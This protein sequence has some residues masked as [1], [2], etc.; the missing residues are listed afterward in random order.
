[1]E[2][3]GSIDVI[4]KDGPKSTDHPFYPGFK[5]E[6]KVLEQG[7]ILKD[8]ALALPCDI[9]WE[10]DV[11]MKLRDGCT[12]YLDIYRRADAES[13]LPS[14]IASG[15]FGKNGGVNRMGT[16][17]SPWRTGIPQR[18]V[19]S[20][21]KFEG[22]DPAYW[23][24]HGY[25]IVHPD[26]RGTWMSEGD[27]YI[28]S[29][30]DG[31][32][33]YDIVEWVAQQHWSNQRVTF[34]GNSYLSQTQW[35]VG[36]EQPPHLTCL[37]P[38]EGWNDMYNDSARRGGIPAPGFQQSLLDH[39]AVG[40]GRTEDVEAMTH[41]Y[42]LWNEYWEDR[43]ARCDRITVPLYIVASWTNALH[44]RGTFRGWT[45]AA[46][47]QKWLRVHNSHEWPDFYYPQNVEDLR[48]FYDYFMKDVENGWEYTPRVRLCVLNPGHQDVVNRPEQGFPLARQLSR[49]LYLNAADATMEWES[50][51]EQDRQSKV[52]FDACTGTADFFYTFPERTEITGY[53]KLKLWVQ[54]IGNNDMD[55]FVKYSKLDVS[56]NLLESTCIDVGY[57]QGNAEAERQRLREM[58]SS[59]D[60]DTDVF[61]AEGATGRL[62]ISHRELDPDRST[63]HQPQYSH[64]RELLLKEGEI[65]PVHIELWPYAMIWEQGEQIKLS[66][67]GHNLRPEIRPEVALAA[68]LNKGQ[69]VIYTGGDNDS[70]LLV[71]FVP[72]P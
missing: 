24:L 47:T 12:I 55:I 70:H 8:G 37:A 17:R 39:C 43:R 11:P 27:T 69:I 2:K 46:S 7:S 19:S 16:D 58:H 30:L 67:A 61:F 72:S 40:Q 21:E 60:P 32:D 56:G 9:L 45:E 31:K 34:A 52:E 26:I 63:P 13:G 38:W 35:F 57:L 3:V 23:C 25:A 64:Q 59:G 53:S 54:A 1:M 33:G 48:K 29:T 28:N 14:I 10:R 4:F 22:P 66:I 42:P 36:A 50:P 51:F 15:P 71:P 20:L 6:T 49:R 44:T 41:R 68:T 18:T 62:R 5:Q 65:V